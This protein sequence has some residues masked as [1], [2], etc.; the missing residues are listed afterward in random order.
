MKFSNSFCVYSSKGIPFAYAGLKKCWSLEE[1]EIG[2]NVSE[3]VLL[4]GGQIKVDILE[5][6]GVDV[7]DG[8]IVWKLGEAKQLVPKEE[9]YKTSSGFVL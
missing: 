7:V 1:R 3:D 5:R 8:N 2:N 9:F 6:V 4:F